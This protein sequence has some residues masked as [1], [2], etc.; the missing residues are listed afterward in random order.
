M[1]TLNACTTYII[2]LVSYYEFTNSSHETSNILI[3]AAAIT[4]SHVAQEYPVGIYR[5]FFLVL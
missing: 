4:L 3:I 2:V 1:S 5:Y